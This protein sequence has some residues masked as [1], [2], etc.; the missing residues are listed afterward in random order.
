MET[1]VTCSLGLSVE[2]LLQMPVEV[3]LLGGQYSNHFPGNCTWKKTL[4]FC[5]AIATG[6]ATGHA[7]GDCSSHSPSYNNMPQN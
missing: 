7:Q 3:A 6:G 1:A 2:L 4:E 5:I